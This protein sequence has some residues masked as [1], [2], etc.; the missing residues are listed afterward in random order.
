M[1]TILIQNGAACG[2]FQAVCEDKGEAISNIQLE[3]AEAVVVQI[4]AVN[5]A[6]DT[7]MADADNAQIGQ[8]L[9]SITYAYMK[10]RSFSSVT[11]TDYNGIATLI[12][13]T[14]VVTKTA[15]TS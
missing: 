3:A 4:L 13:N 14:C 5:A 1:A 7:P 6:L 10:G 11:P 15:L 8:L 2:A 9:Q 12:V